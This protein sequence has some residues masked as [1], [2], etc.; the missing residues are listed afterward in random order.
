MEDIEDISLSA[1]RHQ[2]LSRLNVKTR[3]FPLCCKSQ[4]QNDNYYYGNNP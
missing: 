2:A 1:S 3:E 4:E